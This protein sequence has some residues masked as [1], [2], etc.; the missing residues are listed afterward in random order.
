M[1]RFGPTVSITI[2]KRDGTSVTLDFKCPTLRRD[3]WNFLGTHLYKDPLL[4]KNWKISTL[5]AL[6]QCCANCGSTKKVE[7][8]HIKHL[9][10]LNAKLD[11]FFFSPPFF[12][13]FFFCS[14]FLS[15]H[16]TVQLGEVKEKGLKVELGGKGGRKD[17]GAYKP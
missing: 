16:L 9:R 5:T 10:G 4:I 14:P 11:S 1:A 12:F 7:M 3:S 2:H 13:F 6:G 15:P 17:D 8:H